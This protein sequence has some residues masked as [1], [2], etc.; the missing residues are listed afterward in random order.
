MNLYFVFLVAL[1]EELFFRGFVQPSA[2]RREVELDVGALPP[3]LYVVT[4]HVSD[5][6]RSVARLL[7][8]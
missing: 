7:V 2:D 5:G 6:R 4:A 8:R 1:G 3:G